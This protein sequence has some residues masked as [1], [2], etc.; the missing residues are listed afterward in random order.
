[1]SDYKAK[2]LKYKKKYLNLKN[3][4]E[5]GKPKVTQHDIEWLEFCN[6]YKLSMS[7]CN[8]LKKGAG[9]HVP[10]GSV[11]GGRHVAKAGYD[12]EKFKK[13]GAGK[14]KEGKDK[15]MTLALA[16]AREDYK[17]VVAEARARR[18]KQGKESRGEKRKGKES[19]GE[20][21]KGRQM[22]LRERKHQLRMEEM[23]RKKKEEAKQKRREEFEKE[24]KAALDEASRKHEEYLRLHP[25]EIRYV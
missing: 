9:P 25:E 1:M 2:Y 8:K 16:K 21:R 14:V 17:S 13:E 15:E 7:E 23:Q 20:K 12:Y 6:Y 5:G 22:T 19:R 11:A 10:L 18:K 3:D 24:K 4:L